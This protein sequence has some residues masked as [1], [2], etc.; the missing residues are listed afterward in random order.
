LSRELSVTADARG[1]LPSEQ[2]GHDRAA[3]GKCDVVRSIG[4]DADSFGNQTHEQI[5]GAPG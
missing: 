3:S 2:R 1:D 5:V 4:R